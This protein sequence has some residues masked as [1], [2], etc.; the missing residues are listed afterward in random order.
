MLGHGRISDWKVVKDGA[1]TPLSVHLSNLCTRIEAGYQVDEL[2]R[3]SVGGQ[4]SPEYQQPNAEVTQ[5]LGEDTKFQ[6]A[7]Y[8]SF[9]GE[10]LWRW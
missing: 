10:C 3:Y 8:G 4:D 2:G 9:L 7:I 5:T 6:D 1:I